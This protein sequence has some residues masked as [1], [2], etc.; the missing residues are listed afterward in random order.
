M[1]VS[2]YWKQL[3][4]SLGARLVSIPAHR[5]T[6]DSNP[7]AA[8]THP[9]VM[10]LV[11]SMDLTRTPTTLSP[12]FRSFVAEVFSCRS[13]PALMASLARSLSKKT[14]SMTIPTSSP[15]I[16]SDRRN[17]EPLGETIFAPLTSHATLFLSSFRP[18]ESCQDLDIPSPH[19]T[20][21]P[22]SCLFSI[23]RTLAPFFAAHLAV[24]EPAGPAP[25]TTTS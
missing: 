23:M 2:L 10:S 20:G 11:P 13:E 19:L 15:A 3:V 18:T 21:E 12:S 22:I 4:M 14:L 24:M 16:F 17:E 5:P 7:S 8:T 6:W 1:F 25:T 9:H